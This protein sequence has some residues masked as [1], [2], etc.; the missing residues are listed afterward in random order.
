MKTNPLLSAVEWFDDLVAGK[1]AILRCQWR[2]AVV[3]SQRLSGKHISEFLQNSHIRVKSED[4]DIDSPT[5]STPFPEPYTLEMNDG[6]LVSFCLIRGS[7]SNMEA[8]DYAAKAECITAKVAGYMN[9]AR[10]NSYSFG[11]YFLHDPHTAG[12]VFDQKIEPM[13]ATAK[14]FGGNAERFKQD[15]RRKLVHG[16]AEEMALMTVRT[17]RSVLRPDE[18]KQADTDYRQMIGNI[19]KSGRAVPGLANAI[20]APYGQALLTKS[21]RT[22]QSHEGMTLTLLND[23]NNRNIGISIMLLGV[24]EAFERV[25]RFGDR[26][27]PQAP[28]WRARL[29]GQPGS[30][31]SATP[32]E[33]PLPRPLHL[34]MQV[35][36]RKVIGDIDAYEMSTI[37]HTWY[38]TSV[39][40]EGQIGR[41]HV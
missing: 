34:G 20:H 24:S 6:T 16:A 35:L 18:I 29:T 17:H 31:R 10:A 23:F 25:R 11:L 15:L 41:A 26:E 1:S 9:G 22:L 13:L 40:L 14:R 33:N 12:Q 2:G 21:L 39:V 30:L 19:M 36:D 5:S 28:H 7:R 37:G 8:V 32:S 3:P 27:L 4:G 38:G